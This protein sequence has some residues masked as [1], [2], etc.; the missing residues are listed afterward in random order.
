[1]NVRTDSPLFESDKYGSRGGSRRDPLRSVRGA[2]GI[3]TRDGARPSRGGQHAAILRPAYE[4]GNVS[5]SELSLEGERERTHNR[6][7][8]TQLLYR[9][10]SRF[11][12]LHASETSLPLRTVYSISGFARV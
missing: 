10:P 3:P 1:M 8:E 7:F 4:L 6:N 2:A 11:E 12:R 5:E 9:S